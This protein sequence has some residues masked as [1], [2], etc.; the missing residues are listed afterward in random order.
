[1]KYNIILENALKSIIKKNLGNK[2]TIEQDIF[3]YRRTYEYLNLELLEKA[4]LIVE[5]DK[6][7]SID[8]SELYIGYITDNELHFIFDKLI[9]KIPT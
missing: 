2:D 3:N 1:M 6:L 4:F 7:K 9:K 5:L 8:L